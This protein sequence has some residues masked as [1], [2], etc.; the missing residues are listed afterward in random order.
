MIKFDSVTIK[1]VHEFFSLLNFNLEIK[2]NTLIVGDFYSGST[3]IVRTLT[4]L[5]KNY[6]GEI[7]IDDINIKEIKDKDLT[8][9]YVSE[10]PYLFKH[11]SIEKNLIFPL[12]IRKNLKK[13][14]KNIVKNAIFNYKLDTFPKSVKKLSVTEQKLLTL[15]RASLWKPKYIILEN[16]FER[17]DEKYFELAYKIINDIKQ[18]S[19]IIATEKENKNIQIFNDFEIVNL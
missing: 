18:H 11:K 5:D 12:K 2:N 1:Y 7:Y 6:T 14:A 15:I 9:A 3:A 16:F 10:T 4:K 17:L 13:D 8:I 19:I